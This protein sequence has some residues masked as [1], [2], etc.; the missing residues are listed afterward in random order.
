MAVDIAT[1]TRQ[2]A[3][4]ALVG[5]EIENGGGGRYY[6]DLAG[7]RLLAARLALNTGD[8]AEA[9]RHWKE[10]C[11]LL[12]AY[13][14]HKDI[15]IY[16]LLDPLP[17][18][19][20]LD[21]ARGRAAV[22]KVQ[23]LCERI[24]QH[25]DGKET[26][27]T[28]S[29][30]RELL[31]TA[32][33]CTLAKLITPRLL[34]S[35]NDPDWL[36]HGA[37]SDLW[38]AWYR[39]AD[40]IVA[41]ALRLTLEE[42]LDK[43]DPHALGLL[44]DES[45]GSGRDEPARLLI[46]LLGRTDERPSK[47]SYSNGDEFLDRD[48]EQ[49]DALNAIAVRVVVPRIAPLPTS[50]SQVVNPT[51]FSGGRRSPP[52]VRSPDQSE[53]MS[54]PDV[55]SLAHAIRAWR[56]RR[57]DETHPGW[58]V[59]R[60]A[61]ALGDRIVE[62]AEAGHA[63]DADTALRLIADAG[64][65]DDRSG[66]LKALAEVLERH[67]Q[68]RL[69]A[70]AYTLA[71]T[72]RRGRG[73]WI[74][75]GGETEIESLARA[76]NLDRALVLSTVAG[77]VERVISQQL[78]SLGAT[79][80]LVY[81]F[82]KGGLDA[83]DP[84][85]IW[86]E[87]FAVIADRA[88]RVAD[89]DDPDDVYVVP[90]PDGGADLLG[91]IDAAFAAA[92]VAGLAHPG[93]EQK[94]RSFVAV[95]LLID[96]RT[97]VVAPALKSALLSLSDPATLTW[98]L[99]VIEMAGDKA[100][101][102]ITASRRRLIEL[103]RSPHLTVR[104]LAR[105]LLPSD[106]IP[107]C[108]PNEAD[109][110]LLRGGTS[111]VLLLPGDSGDREGS[112]RTDKIVNWQAG[113]RLSRAERILPRLREAVCKRIDVAQ[114]DEQLSARMETQLRVLR[115]LSEKRWPDAF[116]AENEAIED[117][118]Q[119]AS[120]GVRAIRLMKGE[121]FV[122]PF[123]LEQDLAEAVLDDPWLP[124]ALERTRQPRPNLPP[125]PLRGDSLWQA[126]RVRAEGEGVDET[127]VQAAR[128]DG[129]QLSGTMAIMETE[130]VPTLEG[131]PYS[132]W[133]LVASVEQRTIAKD[134]TGSA[135]DDVARRYRVVEVRAEGDRQALTVPPISRGNLRAWTTVPQSRPSV[136]DDISTQPIVGLDFT[137]RVVGDGHGGLGIQYN[138]F[139]PTPWLTTV[140]G[141][142][143]GSDFVLDD[144]HGEAV[145]LVTWRTE[146]ETSEYELTWPRLHGA[147]LVVRGDVFEDLIRTAQGLL[148]FRDFVEGSSS[149]CG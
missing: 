130:S 30:W 95:Q 90:D 139:T 37:R 131:G 112:T 28:W 54:P 59:E 137:V 36:L 145:A 60:F 125:P 122:D 71:W 146:Y 109:P 113:V 19:I 64:G 62:L 118:M 52:V 108:P 111:D 148:T 99:R 22:A 143:Q 10:A 45:D 89:I 73:G 97:T 34:G 26:R 42:P 133:R 21:P 82:A 23:E 48:Q 103:A 29:R 50:A 107:P 80:A 119:R 129:E 85:D 43:N 69:A 138:L 136:C 18:L 116:L 17:T 117:A 13:G 79:Q 2:A 104:V 124:L 72:R 68:R 78:G 144:R 63:N 87:A 58:S 9:R 126:L 44:A 4:Q 56:D 121:P 120:A 115:S 31:A 106:D 102:I 5:D 149:L 128:H 110:E 91:D 142:T 74:A 41:G 65:F 147:G 100:A 14:W 25:T 77:E 105:R 24:P 127:G 81:G 70:V 123:K 76:T 75:F 46:A 114:N 98:L 96:Q 39:R 84:F 140:L 134:T 15:T 12:T 49:V 92:T 11:R 16:E 1:S 33:P 32:D 3:A 6:S 61:N 94:R 93:R 132:G 40:P 67:G 88:P 38:R 141:L 27:H 20:S 51:P 86:D 135:E 55:D 7:Y 101:P 53:I 83:S 35:C 66:L 47:Y 8:T 57:Y